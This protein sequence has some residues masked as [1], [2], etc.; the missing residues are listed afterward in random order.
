[1]L[2]TVNRIYRGSPTHL[3][4]PH[5]FPS[6]IGYPTDWERGIEHYEIDSVPFP[7]DFLQKRWVIRKECWSCVS[8]CLGF[9][10]TSQPR[11]I[12]NPKE[13]TH[14]GL[15][16]TCTEVLWH[17]AMCDVFK[18]YGQDE[19]SY[20]QLPTILYLSGTGNSNSAISHS[21]Q[22]IHKQNIMYAK[23]PGLKYQRQIHK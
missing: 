23:F 15:D 7:T 2:K 18:I 13:H 1:M 3:Y 12:S 14:V 8:F 21:K 17:Q 11:K 5:D 19:F 20:F 6:I 9:K 22:N 4:Y 10:K 16:N